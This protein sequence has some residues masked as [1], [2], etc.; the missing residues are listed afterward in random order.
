MKLKSKRSTKLFLALMLI[1]GIYLLKTIM[2]INVSNRYSAPKSLKAPLEVIWAHK[3]ELCDEFQT[4]CLFRRE[5]QQKVQHK[6][7]QAK[8][9]T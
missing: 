2:G 1:Y 7:Q 5:I 8:H 9:A 6:I 3:T 4:L